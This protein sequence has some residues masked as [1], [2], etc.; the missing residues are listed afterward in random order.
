MMNKPSPIPPGMH[1]VTPHLVCAGAA[2]AIAFYKKAFNAQELAQLAGPDGKLM[3]GMIKIGDSALMLVDEYPQWDSLGPKARNGTSVTLHLYVEDADAQFKQAIDAGCS[4]RM[5]LA[6]MF[7]GDRY[8]IVQ[9]PFGHLWSIATH[10]RDVSPEEIRA[11][12]EKG[13]SGA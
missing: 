9:D 1:S 8:G 10:V 11:A 6:D 5:P 2:D 13:C 4:V 12:A 7:W 3:H